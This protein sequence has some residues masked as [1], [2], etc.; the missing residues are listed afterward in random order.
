VA[1]DG[2]FKSWEA[3]QFAKRL[4]GRWGN[5]LSEAAD[6]SKE[7]RA[8]RRNLTTF[9]AKVLAA[10]LCR[11]SLAQIALSCLQDVLELEDEKKVSARLPVAVT[12]V[13]HC[14][15]QLLAFSVMN[16]FSEGGYS[17]ERWLMWRKRLQGLSRQGDAV[18]AGRRRRDS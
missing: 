1:V 11:D 8:Q 14:H 2:G 9:P 10:G 6:D 3:Y 5:L 12:W 15:H 16:Q 7:S 17:L 18:V 13:Y 4:Q